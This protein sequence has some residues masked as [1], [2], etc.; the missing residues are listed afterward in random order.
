MPGYNV[1]SLIAA[2]ANTNQ[3]SAA[4]AT[5]IDVDFV[6]FRLVCEAIGATPAI[7]WL[8]R[9]SLD[10]PAVPDAN[11]I[12]EPI[13]YITEAADTVAFTARS[14][15]VVAGT[16]QICF[17][18]NPARKYRKYLA[19]ISGILNVTYRAEMFATDVD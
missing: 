17:P 15:P 16:E 9:G 7:T 5:P 11:S 4:K 3:T 18:S 8:I 13:G 2:G 14:G 19:V 10:D 12:F 1:I 6:A